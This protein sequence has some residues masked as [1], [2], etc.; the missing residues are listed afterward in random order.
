MT[1][2]HLRQ[3]VLLGAI[4]TLT[5]PG[6][7]QSWDVPESL[8][9][10]G[11]AS[12]LYQL[13]RLQ[14]PLRVVYVAAHPD[15]ENTRLLAYL[16]KGL[17]ADVTYLSLT[18]GEGGQNLM[19][20]HVGTPLGVIREHELRAARRRDGAQQAFG[21]CAD[22]GYSKTDV[23]TWSQWD[24]ERV[25]AETV[26]WIRK[27][28]P[29]WIITR[30]SPVPGGTHGHHTAS[31]QIA[32]QAADSAASSTYRTD[33]GPAW[34]VERVFWNSS[35]FFFQNGDLDTVRFRSVNVGVWHPE[36][37]ATYGEIAAQSRS[38][39]KSQGFGA[40]GTRGNQMEYFELLRG[41]LP[42]SGNPLDFQGK[43]FWDRNTQN[44]LTECEKHLRL[45]HWNQAVTA[46][47]RA[48]LS[49]SKFDMDS[50]ERA[51]WNTLLLHLWCVQMEIRGPLHAVA[52]DTVAIEW[53]AIARVPGVIRTGLG[54]NYDT[55][56]VND[57]QKSPLFYPLAP[58]PMVVHV[59]RGSIRVPVMLESHYKEVDPIEGERYSK[60][61][62][63]QAYSVKLQVNKL[64]FVSGFSPSFEVEIQPNGSR[65]V[66]EGKFQWTLE[67]TGAEGDTAWTHT[68]TESF[69]G[70]PTEWKRTISVPAAP[71]GF[72]GSARLSGCWMTGPEKYCTDWKDLDYRHLPRLG[73]AETA[74]LKWAVLPSLPPTR[75]VGVLP[76][77]GDDVASALAALGHRVRI[78]DPLEPTRSSL[79][80]LDA[81]VLGVR[82]ANVWN[83]R[84][85]AWE[86]VLLDWA[87]SGKT[88]LMEYQTTADLPSDFLN[89]L[90]FSLRRNR[91]TEENQP[92][93]LFLPNHPRAHV[94][95]AWNSGTWSG[96]VQERSLYHGV[97][98][99]AQSLLRCA[100]TGEA[101]QVGLVEVIP[102][103]RGNIIYTGLSLFRQWPQG[104]PGSFEVLA[105]LVHPSEK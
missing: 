92:M 7:S 82:F 44:R 26:T 28:R 21:S 39:H 56:T 66:R 100:D 61:L 8:Q 95:Y 13:K 22:F 6:W 94:P 29:H 34:N 98:P 93:E 38:M 85:A 47:E 84:W 59:Q 48:Y 72:R 80:G 27:N 18:R 64:A 10:K 33:L 83:E 65:P 103:G 37:G 101:A 31:A 23:E 99:G 50:A 16:A 24:R 9:P 52:G 1:V 11:T 81:V 12:A 79:D 54:L 55:L 46:G 76:G 20:P 42:P 71:S 60:T 2:S 90:Q 32:V 74:E 4:L 45:G 105:N 15:D 25:L 40:A 49:R 36:T 19:G 104:V 5:A 77:S 78:L 14:Q 58:A 70:N 89:P 69:I 35:A 75:T 57:W 96:W 3:S 63:K 88:V 86:T 17:H 97:A 51:Q 68:Q 62:F 67:Y 73:Y 91:I 102:W 43:P 87:Y 30:F 53:N 41:S